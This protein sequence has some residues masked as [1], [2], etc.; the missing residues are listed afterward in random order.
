M[1]YRKVGVHFSGKVGVRRK[2]AE[3][4]S[5]LSTYT[6]D[7]RQKLRRFFLV[8]SVMENSGRSTCT[9]P[10]LRDFYKLKRQCFYF[11]EQPICSLVVAHSVVKN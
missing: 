7:L 8:F 2:V 11:S 6:E 3:N 4:L 5:E 1:P 9:V 10:V